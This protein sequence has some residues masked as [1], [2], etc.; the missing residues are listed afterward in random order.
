MSAS[1]WA[2][3]PDQIVSYWLYNEGVIR[4]VD[5]VVISAG[6]VIY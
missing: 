4:S 3:L 2:L 6:N 5:L 1:G